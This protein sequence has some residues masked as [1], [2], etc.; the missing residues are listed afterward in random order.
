MDFLKLQK[1]TLE[2]NYSHYL[3]SSLIRCKTL[4]RS[5]KFHITRTKNFKFNYFLLGDFNINI[6]QSCRSPTAQNYLDMLSSHALYPTITRPTRIT[7]NFFTIIDHIITNCNS[8]DISPGIIESDL[9]DHYTVFCIIQNTITRK[10]HNKYY[11]RA[12]KNFDSEKF[13][14][15]FASKL[16]N[17]DLPDLNVNNVNNVFDEILEIISSTTNTHA[18]LKLATRKKQKILSKPWL[19]KGNIKSIRHKQFI[20]KSFYLL[21]SDQQKLFYKRYANKLF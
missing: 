14:V 20:H 4:Y 12:M 16:H 9:T 15:D 3:S 10:R 13:P 17:Y 7:P 2:D 19:T 11:Y 21:G 5:I 18:P 6:S 1:I 8:H